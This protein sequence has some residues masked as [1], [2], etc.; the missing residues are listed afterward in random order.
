MK[1]ICLII[2][3]Y[4]ITLLTSCSEGGQDP[5]K[6]NQAMISQIKSVLLKED[7][8]IEIIKKN[9]PEKLNISFN[10]LIQKI[11]SSIYIIQH[12]KYPQKDS[13]L[14]ISAIHLLKVYKTITKNVYP[15]VIRIAKIPDKDYSKADDELIKLASNEINTKL[16]SALAIFIKTEKVFADKYQIEQITFKKE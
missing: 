16:D 8:L 4:L 3:I 11:D 15:E 9:K 6:Y 14:R 12:L 13:S 5:E 1:L 2:S 7:S 10:K